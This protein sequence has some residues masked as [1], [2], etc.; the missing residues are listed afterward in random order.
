MSYGLLIA[1]IISR[2]P[3]M[4]LVPSCHFLSPLILYISRAMF[5]QISLVR[6]GVAVQHKYGYFMQVCQTVVCQSGFWPSNDDFLCN[7]SDAIQRV[8]TSNSRTAGMRR[9]RRI[10]L[11]C[12]VSLS[13]PVTVTSLLFLTNAFHHV[14]HRT[15]SCSEFKVRWCSPC[16]RMVYGELI[17]CIAG[18]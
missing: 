14:L 3:R 9:R 6:A 10:Q 13:E 12:I 18:A 17:T 2:M 1:F 4:L 5:G 7:R 16:G 15:K 11:S 8:K